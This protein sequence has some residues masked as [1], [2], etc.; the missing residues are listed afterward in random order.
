MFLRN[1]RAVAD[2]FSGRVLIFFIEVLIPILG[3]HISSTVN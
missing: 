2:R 3:E 1:D